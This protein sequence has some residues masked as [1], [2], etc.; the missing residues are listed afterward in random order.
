[1]VAEVRG[2]GLML[3]MQLDALVNAREVSAQALKKGFVV[4]IAGNNTL[5]FTPPLL[6]QRG[7]IDA[8]IKCL[9]SVLEA[10]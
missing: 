3:G 5:R 9:R 8:L 10:F 6:I 1:F 4:G 7:H 2:R